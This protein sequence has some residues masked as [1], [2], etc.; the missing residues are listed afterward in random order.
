MEATNIHVDDLWPYVM[1][2]LPADLD[3]GARAWEAL[4]RCRGVPNASALLRMILA[5]GITDLSLKDVA[6]WAHAANVAEVSGPGLFYRVREAEKWLSALLADVLGQSVSPPKVGGLRLRIVDATVI[7]GPGAVGTEWR[8]H[9]QLDPAAARL[10]AVEITDEHEGEGYARYHVSVGDVILGDRGYAHASG[11]AWVHTHGGYV[12]ARANPHTIRLCR[13]DR[14]VLN[15]LDERCKVP[16]VGVYT[17]VI[18]IPIP[19]VQR[20]RS[21]KTWSLNKASAWIPG[22]LL[23]ARTR[24]GDIIWVLTTVPDHLA[25]D[26]QI[27]DLYRVRW[28]VELLIKRLKSLLGIDGLPSRK[29]PT[30]RS[31]LLA[32]LLAAALA[33]ELVQPSGGFPPWGY[34]L[35]VQQ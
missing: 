1:T 9:M 27:M 7:T 24:L 33:Q 5:Y 23:G 8:I 13:T 10:C 30:A 12:V 25:S 35:H 17:L 28:Q 31:W 18:E 4:K 21:H 15:V 2:Y 26:T 3:E 29:G 16:R 11:V 6:A 14:T 20:S 34:N 22:R 19:P 32:R